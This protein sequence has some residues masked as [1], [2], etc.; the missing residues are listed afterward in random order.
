MLIAHHFSILPEGVPE[1]VHLVPAGTFSGVDGRGPFS[2]ADAAAVIARSMAEAG[3]LPLD[4]NH[5][6]DLAGPAGNPSPARG[7]IVEL[8]ARDDGIWGRVEW[9]ETGAAM[10]RDKAY[11]G[12]S[13]VFIH[14]KGGEVLGVLRAALTNT[15]NL[16]Q[17]TALFH[18]QETGMDLERLRTALG[19]PGT[20]DEAAILAAIE[21][22][23]TAASVHA[24]LAAGV[25][26]AIGL[27]AEVPDDGI[28]VALNARTAAGGEVARMAATITTLE[29]QVATMQAERARDRAVAF[30]DGAIRAG[31][32]IVALRDHYIARHAAHPVAVE[33][34]VNAL[35]S[36]NAGGA[37]QNVNPG[38]PEAA[39]T[40][41]AGDQFVAARMGIDPKA[42]AEF[43]QKRATE[44]QGGA[45]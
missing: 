31:K 25:R 15:P 32:P 13:P 36:I 23:R 44:M 28:L 18:T 7:W 41:T 16:T 22:H 14:A 30:I 37:P 9:T 34:E 2:L 6:T 19:L 8:Q 10:M 39:G 17:L 5:S 27:G 40:L 29:T 3:R 38:Q 12:I 45:A 1:W 35:V 11:R 43:R 20:A 26:T 42:L 4:E 24:T 21:T 33:T